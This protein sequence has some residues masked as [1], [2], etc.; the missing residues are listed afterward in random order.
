M[1]TED[2]VVNECSQGQVVEEVGETLPDICIAI[3]AQTFVVE[4]V[5]LRD[6]SGF[7]VS[8]ENCDSLRVADFECDKESD[9]LDRKVAPVNVVTYFLSEFTSVIVFPSRVP[10]NR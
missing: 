9:S 8:S 4:A 1:E 5:D 10:M 2:L 7:V 3:F 6:L